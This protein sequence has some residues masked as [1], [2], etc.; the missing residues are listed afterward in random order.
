MF[1]NLFIGDPQ[2][3]DSLKNS[4]E[5]FSLEK[6]ENNRLIL[7]NNVNGRWLAFQRMPKNLT[8]N[9]KLNQPDPHYIRDQDTDTLLGFSNCAYILGFHEKVTHEYVNLNPRFTHFH[10]EDEEEDKDLSQVFVN[11]DTSVFT[12]LI[13]EIPEGAYVKD[14]YHYGGHYYGFI[15]ELEHHIS[16]T[17]ASNSLRI[18]GYDNRIPKTSEMSCFHMYKLSVDCRFAIEEELK[19]IK[20]MDP[21]D[22]NPNNKYRSYVVSISHSGMNN[23]ERKKFFRMRSMYNKNANP[24]ILHLSGPLFTNYIIGTIPTKEARELIEKAKRINHIPVDTDF[25]YIYISEYDFKDEKDWYNNGIIP[26][27]MELEYEKIRA[28]T[29][30]EDI[31]IRIR[32]V[33]KARIQ[34]VLSLHEDGTI[35]SVISNR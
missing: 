3:V 25:H 13:Y 29:V 14:T 22:F 30:T 4:E 2:S 15:L 11:I 31:R 34:Q 1:V 16:M 9:P 35:T 32:D 18:Y 5:L 12:P 17:E 7:R 28:V 20:K 33:R 8:D 24:R 27:L 10:P 21:E 23:K 19:D 6:K 26:Q